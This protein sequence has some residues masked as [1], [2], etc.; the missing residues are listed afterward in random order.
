MGNNSASKAE[1]SGWAPSWMK[2]IKYLYNCARHGN[3]LEET[4]MDKFFAKTKGQLCE[5]VEPISVSH[6]G[7]VA[8]LFKTAA[9]EIKQQLDNAELHAVSADVD[10]HFHAALRQW[11][12]AL[13]ELKLM[14][15]YCIVTQDFEQHVGLVQERLQEIYQGFKTNI[16]KSLEKV[17]NVR[18]RLKT[19]LILCGVMVGVCLLGLVALVALLALHFVPFVNFALGTVELCV[20]G[21][22]AVLLLSG[23]GASLAA[24]LWAAYQKWKNNS[25]EENANLRQN[26]ANTM[27]Q[28]MGA[29][30]NL[31][32]REELRKELDRMIEVVEATL[33]SMDTIVVNPSLDED[34]P[35]LEE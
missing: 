26:Q 30:L 10:K 11:C 14:L 1:K 3:F 15:P 34:Y 29:V 23:F 18:Q 6:L 21:A 17:K 2:E 25:S 27:M 28:Q 33:D 12:A 7:E 35:E 4:D 31:K 24:I 19:L 5:Q 20:V 16:L 9:S 22:G 13:N 32:Q 8:E